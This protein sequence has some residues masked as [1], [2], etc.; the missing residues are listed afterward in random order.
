VKPTAISVEEA[1]RAPLSV[2]D[3]NMEQES[4]I[5]SLFMEWRRLKIFLR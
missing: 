5:P 1:P 2:I 3:V 4:N